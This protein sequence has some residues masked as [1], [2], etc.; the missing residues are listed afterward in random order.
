M[1]II[2]LCSLGGEKLMGLR[3]LKEIF[4]QFPKILTTK[5]MYKMIRHKARWERRYCKQDPKYKGRLNTYFM[6]VRWLM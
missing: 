6:C 5:E 1:G 4:P 3:A 2:W